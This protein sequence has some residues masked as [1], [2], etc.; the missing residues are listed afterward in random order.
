MKDFA[1]NAGT[2]MEMAGVAVIVAGAI[3]AAPLAFARRSDGGLYRQFR[4]GLGRSI[5]LG[6]EFLVAADIIMT[7]AVHP[8]MANVVVLSI[9]VLI[10]TFL[11]LTLEMEINHRW[12]WQ[13]RSR[14]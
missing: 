5:L 14:H 10:R 3:L 12:P 11:S 6:L 8:T 7:V 9:I 1:Q 13:E 4:R 2:L